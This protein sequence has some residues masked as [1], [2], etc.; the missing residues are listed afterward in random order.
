MTTPENLPAPG[1]DF[2][3]LPKGD[4]IH[5]INEEELTRETEPENEFR[6]LDT[7]NWQTVKGHMDIRG[8]HGDQQNDQT[9]TCGSASS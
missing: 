6:N 7:A 2:L 1:V 8:K 3:W 4:P 9:E 5:P